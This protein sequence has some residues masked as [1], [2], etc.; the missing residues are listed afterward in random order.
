MSGT[1]S[2]PSKY[3]CIKWEDIKTVR[4][5]LLI[6][7]GGTCPICEREIRDGEACLDHHHK[8]RIKGTG[9]IRGVLCRTCNVL[10]GK[11]ENNCVRYS[12]AHSDLPRVLRNM[13]AYMERRQLPYIHPSDRPKEPKIMRSSYNELCR[14]IASDQP[15]RRLPEYPKSGKLTKPL[16]KLYREIGMIPKFYK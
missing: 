9:K 16:K 15:S 7:Q 3:E 1:R 12:V 11:M 4:D 13:A 14:R 5:A 2:M 6:K 8:K 10:L